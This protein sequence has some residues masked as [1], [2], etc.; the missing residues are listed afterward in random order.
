MRPRL[1]SPLIE[2]S[3][4][5]SRTTL[6]DWFHR[7]HTT[8]VNVSVIHVSAPS[9]LRDTACLE[10]SRS[11]SVLRRLA[12]IHRPSPSSTSAPAVRVLSSAG[13]ARPQQSYDPVRRPPAPPPPLTTLRPLPSCRTGLPQLPGSPFQ[14]AVPT[15]PMDRN[16][17]VCR[18]LPRSTRAFPVIQAGR[19]P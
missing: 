5:I 7:E 17:R 4:R 10:G 2:R 18:L 3:M 15:T 12:P 11:H 13:V 8:A 6:S 9:W 19:R 14:H 16:G 1:P